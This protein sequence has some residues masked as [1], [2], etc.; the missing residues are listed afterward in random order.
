MTSEPTIHVQPTMYRVCA[1]PETDPDV[2]SFAVNVEYRGS[3]QWA[4]T[5]RGRCLS[6]AGGWDVEP[7]PGLRDGGFLA[8]HRF[9]LD[10]AL[11]LAEKAARELAAAL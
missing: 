4:V 3:G 9:P 2:D 5:R 7:N 1:L 8:G 10:A 11:E 6:T